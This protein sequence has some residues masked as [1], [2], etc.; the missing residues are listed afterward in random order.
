MKIIT[1]KS[2]VFAISFFL[3]M[4]TFNHMFGIVNTANAY[5]VDI[6]PSSPVVGEEITVTLV[7]DSETNYVEWYWDWE[8]NKNPDPDQDGFIA[9]H[10]YN[11]PGIYK[12]QA[13]RFYDTGSYSEFF[14][15]VVMPE[16]SKDILQQ[17]YSDVIINMKKDAMVCANENF[18]GQYVETLKN[19]IENQ[20]SLDLDFSAFYD[21]DN[22][23]VSNILDE[24]FDIDSTNKE[25]L[26]DQLLNAF[27]KCQ[28]CDINHV[29]QPTFK[30]ILAK[31]VDFSCTIYDEDYI[32]DIANQVVD[33]IMA[34]NS[35]SIIVDYI[36][37]KINIPSVD[38]IVAI[39]FV[40]ILGGIITE[41]PVIHTLVG[42]LA[43]A[44]VALGVVVL[45]TETGVNSYIGNWITDVIL[46][47]TGISISEDAGLAITAAVI[48]S[49]VFAGF[50]SLYSISH[51]L[52]FTTGMVEA[53]VAC[54]GT[55]YA[56]APL[57]QE[58]GKLVINEIDPDPEYGCDWIE[59]Y[60]TFDIDVFLD[61]CNISINNGVKYRI[62]ELNNYY[63]DA[64][65]IESGEYLIIR[66]NDSYDEVTVL[67]LTSSPPYNCVLVIPEDIGPND[68]LT[69]YKV[70]SNK[71]LDEVQLEGITTLTTSYSACPNGGDTFKATEPS[72]GEK[73]IC[74]GGV[75]IP[76][77]FIG[78][79]LLNLLFRWFFYRHPNA[80]PIFRGLF[81]F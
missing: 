5:Q 68:R 23:K 24:L 12:C 21:T 26:N 77:P 40:A 50:F 54:I 66:F 13:I 6:N 58:P 1:K 55:I 53:M 69:I 25:L 48:F 36:A 14:S 71:I 51:V 8:N 30:N 46:K 61:N 29:I 44:V 27:H 18:K 33:A 39:V 60:N 57:L 38:F 72:P 59:L 76:V 67:E 41:L 9:T 22:I 80:F 81:G 10:I 45:L 70:N 35:L 56:I 4:V 31:G 20:L 47:G 15:I 73:N 49:V 3:L 16:I 28:Y 19:T 63:R 74:G 34:D 2:I 65:I 75:P 52:S 42:L 64:T 43:A 78:R 17:D 79:P 32:K 37:N 62:P 11:E 7:E